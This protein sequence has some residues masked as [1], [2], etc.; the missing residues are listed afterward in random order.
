MVSLNNNLCRNNLLNF[1]TVC[2]LPIIVWI[3]SSGCSGF[4][5]INF[6]REIQGLLDNRWFVHSTKIGIN[7]SNEEYPTVVLKEMKMDVIQCNNYDTIY[8]K[9][10]FALKIATHHVN[11]GGPKISSP[12]EDHLE[13]LINNRTD[14]DFQSVED[15]E[16]GDDWQ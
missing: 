14:T 1:S 8:E 9:I 4:D 5:E 3:T 2:T 15:W 10:I 13:E 7:Y 6:E 12:I 16:D 11:V